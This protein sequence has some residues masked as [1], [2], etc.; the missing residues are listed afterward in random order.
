MMTAESPATRTMAIVS[1]AL[2]RDLARVRL[3]LTA[4]PTAL[5]FPELYPI[6]GDSTL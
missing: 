5:K 2:R 3:M 1:A 4:A 6:S